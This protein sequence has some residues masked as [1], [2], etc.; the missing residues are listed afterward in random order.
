MLQVLTSI[1]LQWV[2]V[3]TGASFEEYETLIGWPIIPRQQEVRLP[4]FSQRLLEF[5]LQRC[6]LNSPE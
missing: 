4:A 3:T 1:D 6:L 5:L 2:S